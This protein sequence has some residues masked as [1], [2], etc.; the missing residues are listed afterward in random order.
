MGT[1]SANRTIFLQIAL[2]ILLALGLSLICLRGAS[3]HEGDGCTYM[4]M[5]ESLLAGQGLNGMNGPETRWTPGYSLAIAAASLISGSSVTAGQLISILAS[6]F[7]VIPL[8]LLAARFFGPRVGVWV[9]LLYALSPARI[10]LS[11]AIMTESLFLC[12]FTLAVW[13]WVRESDCFKWY[14]SAAVG[15]LLGYAYLIRPEAFYIAVLVVLISLGLRKWWSMPKLVSCLLMVVAFASVSLPYIGYVH[16]HTGKWTVSSKSKGLSEFILFDKSQESW[17]MNRK[18]NAKCTGVD[19]GHPTETKKQFVSRMLRNLQR[20][21]TVLDEIGSF[22]LVAL[23][24]LGCALELRRGNRELQPAIPALAVLGLPLVAYIPLD[25]SL[26]YVYTGCAPLFILGCWQ[27]HKRFTF[28]NLKATKH[29]S[30]KLSHMLPLLVIAIFLSGKAVPYLT[31]TPAETN[32]PGIAKM[33][34]ANLPQRTS[35]MAT[36]I[37]ISFYSGMDWIVLPVDK[38][39]R[40]I[41]YM[42]NHKTRYFVMTQDD[43]KYNEQW[44]QEIKDLQTLRVISVVDTWSGPNS[45][46]AVLYRLNE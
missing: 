36:S 35:V 16:S 46:G 28:D 22:M 5:A 29:E 27:L 11:T 8:Y 41:R 40:L 31:A 9:S 19:F 3:L 6:V 20:E 32:T 25:P 30:L 44:E 12:V 14:R 34:R 15:I 13:L 2:I 10:S 38:F 23:M 7:T 1:K 18:L 4:R 26:R 37:G 39:D 43:M 33:I 21:I 24:V 17:D 45:D 42:H